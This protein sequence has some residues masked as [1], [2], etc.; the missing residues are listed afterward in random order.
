[1]PSQPNP[2]PVTAT[3]VFAERNTAKVAYSAAKQAT[4][5]RIELLGNPGDQ[6]NETDAT[7]LATHTP[8]IILERPA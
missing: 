4:I 5:E 1:M 6:Y 7:L 2:E 8:A 3:A